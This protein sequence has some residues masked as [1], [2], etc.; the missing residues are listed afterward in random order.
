MKSTNPEHD[1]FYQM[2]QCLNDKFEVRLKKTSMPGH[3][4]PHEQIE[5]TISDYR[6]QRNIRHIRRTVDLEQINMSRLGPVTTFA[7]EIKDCRLK[8]HQE[9][10][11]ET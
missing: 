7:L 4:K 1:P 9:L 10:Q 8:M 2:L 3:Y 5:V 6:D 11:S